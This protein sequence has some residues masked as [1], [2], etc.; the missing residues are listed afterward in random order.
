MSE[1]CYPS[2]TTFLSSPSNLGSELRDMILYLFLK[3]IVRLI[4][5]GSL[6]F[7]IDA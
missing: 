1:I 5:S 3:P 6:D 2:T 4:A 7:G